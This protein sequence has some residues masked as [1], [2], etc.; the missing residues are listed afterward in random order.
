MTRDEHIEHV[1]RHWGNRP[2]PRAHHPLLAGARC[3]Y[4]D[5][6]WWALAPRVLAAPWA[7]AP[8]YIDARIRSQRAPPAVLNG[9]H[10]GAAIAGAG[11][12]KMLPCGSTEY[13]TRIFALY[14]TI[15]PSSIS[16]FSMPSSKSAVLTRWCCS[17]FAAP[18]P[19]GI[20][21]ASTTITV[22]TESSPRC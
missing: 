20:G 2:A 3:A 4:A 7:M 12:F 8:A 10:Q 13:E 15:V 5:L 16:I 18:F 9:L 1:P 19:V 14:P 17:T 6:E 21:T 22:F 11:A